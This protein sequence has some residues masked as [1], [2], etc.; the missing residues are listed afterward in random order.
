MVVV[1]VAVTVQ[2]QQHQL[3][4]IWPVKVKGCGM[5]ARDV[6]GMWKGGECM[7][8]NYSNHMSSVFTN[9]D[10]TKTAPL[11]PLAPPKLRLRELRPVSGFLGLLCKHGIKSI[12]TC[13]L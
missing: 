1:L 3:L 9:A 10:R 8:G 4:A 13:A 7:L 6:G 11:V 12:S 2:E 5:C